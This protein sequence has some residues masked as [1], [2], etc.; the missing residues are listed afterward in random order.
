[1]RL[2]I[3]LVALLAPCTAMAA[4]FDCKGAAT[5]T[6]HAI[7]ADPKLSALDERTFKAY[8]DA[9]GTFGISDAP[10]FRNPIADLLLRGHEAWSQA[11]DHCGTDGS[12]LLAQYLRR[13][14]VLTYHPDPQ[15]HGPADRLIGRY[16]ISIE[17]ARE[18]VVM[19]APGGVVL[20]HVSDGGRGCLLA[21]ALAG[22]GHDVG[23]LE[24][25]GLRGLLGLAG[26]AQS[27]LR[28]N[29]RGLVQRRLGRGL[30]HYLIRRH[31]DQSG[32]Y[33]SCRF[34]Q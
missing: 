1:M 22:F 20:V 34:C 7:C 14:A 8:T 21:D 23:E 18:L 16:A 19:S 32:E 24:S 27:E 13:I 29:H 25:C 9:A 11:R 33:R 31:P 5:T 26:S 10:D 30:A 2:A 4:S 12:C 6:E 17:P 28:G 3:L 15:A